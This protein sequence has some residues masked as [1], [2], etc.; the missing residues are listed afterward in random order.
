MIREKNFP[1]QNQ[2]KREQEETEA[3]IE[4]APEKQLNINTRQR[5]GV[6]ILDI[7]GSI[8]GP[9]SLDLKR[10]IDKEIA[11]CEGEPK[12]LLNFAKVPM[13][14]LSGLGTIV[15]AEISVQRNGGR[16]ILSNLSRNVIPLDILMAKLIQIFQIYEDE[17]EAVASFSQNP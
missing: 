15:A 14:D 7:Q 11:R 16:M 9:E 1:E 3:S 12:L 2:N 5:D 13:M 17:N 4:T 8:I 10:I 6:T